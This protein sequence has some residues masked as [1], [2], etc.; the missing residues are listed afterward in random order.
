MQTVGTASQYPARP[1]RAQQF[2]SARDLNEL[3]R[4]PAPPVVL[5]VRNQDGVT[6]GR[7]E[8]QQGHVPRAVYVDLPRELCGRSTPGAGACPLPAI[9][10]LQESA[11]SWGINDGSAVVVYDNVFGTKAGRAWFVLRWAGLNDV[12]LLDGGFSA[13]VAGAYPV[14]TD[15]RAPCR[16]DV[17]LSPGHLP[18]IDADCAADLAGSGLLLDARG[19]EQY[20]GH[21]HIPGAIAAPTR[22]SLDADGLLLDESQL[23]QRFEMLGVDGSR[24]IG[25]YCGSGVAAAHEFAVLTSLGWAASLYVGSFSAWS[26]DPERPVASGP[27]PD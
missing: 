22:E 3:L 23:K 24:S 25:L 18:V 10:D 27:C 12:R 14:T 13:W 15:E 5:D 2:V 26:S 4:S 16:G 1:R 7:P 21:G 9:S 8:Y 19:R 17:D 20:L 11:R 6:D